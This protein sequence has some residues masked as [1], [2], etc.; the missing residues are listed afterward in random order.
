MYTYSKQVR[1]QSCKMLGNSKQLNSI[2]TELGF[3][4]MEGKTFHNSFIDYCK[5]SKLNRE[6][7]IAMIDSI[8]IAYRK[9]IEDNKE[10]LLTIVCNT[11]SK[12]HKESAAILCK[13][14]SLRPRIFINDE[15][16][17]DDLLKTLTL[18]YSV[19]I[20]L[21]FDIAYFIVHMRN[22][23]QQREL[24][25]IYNTVASKLLCSRMS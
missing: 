13:Y 20:R 24:Q 8:E 2:R 22:N 5:N 6:V 16:Y 19:D 14:A 17:V 21:F 10:Q 25:K 9:F 15:K 4:F 3:W 18:S 7:I 11:L 23:H 12:S 1:E